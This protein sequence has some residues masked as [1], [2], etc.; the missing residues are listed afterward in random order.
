MDDLAAIDRAI[1]DAQ[2]SI[3]S[4]QADIASTAALSDKFK[5]ESLFNHKSTQNE[6]M[7]NNNL[8]RVLGNAEN[9]L[10]IRLN[11]V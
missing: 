8:V 5:S 7:N 6:V 2:I 4:L 1:D 10:K 9:T 11:Q 3:K